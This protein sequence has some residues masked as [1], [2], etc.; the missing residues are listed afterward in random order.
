MGQLGDVAIAVTCCGFTTTDYVSVSLIYF[1]FYMFAAQQDAV[2]EARTAKKK[3]PA[4]CALESL[5][6]GG[7]TGGVAVAPAGEQ[8][9]VAVENPP[10]PVADDDD[11]E[12]IL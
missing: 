5:Q 3:L 9:L 10:V 1:S 8:M 6:G 11:A 4:S 2:N 7:G 12:V